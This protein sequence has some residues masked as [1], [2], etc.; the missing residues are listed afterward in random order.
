MV[1]KVFKRDSINARF[2]VSSLLIIQKIDR[3]HVG[4]AKP[5]NNWGRSHLE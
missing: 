1:F 2:Q 4:Q 3:Q 5:S